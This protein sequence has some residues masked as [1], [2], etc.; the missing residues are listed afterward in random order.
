MNTFGSAYGHP[1]RLEKHKFRLYRLYINAYGYTPNGSYYGIGE[2]I[3]C[4]ACDCG[5]IHKEIRARSRGVAKRDAQEM[6]PN[7]TFYR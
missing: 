7:S 2:P 4:L 3:Y 1:L 5:A 6:Y